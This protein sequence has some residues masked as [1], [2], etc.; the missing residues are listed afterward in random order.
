LSELARHHLRG[1]D[2][3]KAVQYGELAAEQAISRAAY[4]EAA[5]MIQAALK[6]LD[7]LPNEA[8][9][10]RAELPIRNLE[11]VFAFTLYGGA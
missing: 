4:T 5:R 6:L 11:I 7:Q 9:R 3:K 8:E 10:V 2:A 1:N